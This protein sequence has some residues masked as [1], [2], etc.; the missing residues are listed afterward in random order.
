MAAPNLT[1]SISGNKISSVLGFDSITVIF[2]SDSSYKAFECRATKV[3]D[4]WGVGRGALIASFSQTPANTER[5]FDIYDDYL[6][7][8]DGEYRISLL[9]QGESG[10][11]NTAATVLS[12]FEFPFENDSL[13]DSKLMMGAIQDD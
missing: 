2:S 12:L 7:L 3:W 5:Q 8:G 6:L 9:A 1:F 11:W 4:P 10:E 13:D